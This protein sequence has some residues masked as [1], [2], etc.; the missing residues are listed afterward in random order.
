MLINYFH[1]GLLLRLVA[2]LVAVDAR[3]ADDT[4][5]RLDKREL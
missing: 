1:T 4:P 3:L 5:D 2:E